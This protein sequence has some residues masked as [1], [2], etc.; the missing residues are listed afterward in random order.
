MQKLY[1]QMKTQMAIVMK[2]NS[3]QQETNKALQQALNSQKQKTRSLITDQQSKIKMLQNTLNKQDQTITTLKEKLETQQQDQKKVNKAVQKS[4][5]E[6]S[7]NLNL[8]N[9]TQIQNYN[10][11]KRSDELHTKGIGKQEQTNQNQQQLLT[12]LKGEKYISFF[13]GMHFLRYKMN[14][15]ISFPFI[16]FIN[17]L[18]VL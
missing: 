10:T 14:I 15:I 2:E 11:L 1:F 7:Q 8:L 17:F 9:V 3:R 13:S 4:F 12:K 18:F 16:S 6:Q 5:S